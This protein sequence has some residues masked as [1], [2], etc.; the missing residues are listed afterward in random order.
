MIGVDDGA[1]DR[2][3][4]KRDVGEH[5]IDLPRPVAQQEAEAQHQRPDNKGHVAYKTEPAIIHQCLEPDIVGVFT[6]H[7]AELQRA[8]AQ[9]MLQRHEKADGVALEAAVPG[10]VIGLHKFGTVGEQ[11]GDL[12]E[13][14]GYDDRADQ[15]HRANQRHHQD[16]QPE[17]PG[18]FLDQH[19]HDQQNHGDGNETP[20]STGEREEH[21]Q[22]ENHQ[23]G[24][25]QRRSFQRSVQQS[26]HQIESR[27][28]QIGA[29][30]VGI[31]ESAHGA[32]IAG[33]KLSA[34][35]GAEIAQDAQK[36]RDDGCGQIGAKNQDQTP[37][38][39]LDDGGEKH[40]GESQEQ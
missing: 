31:L 32:A 10:A 11:I 21:A 30:H 29:E 36:R 1:D 35:Y 7:Q 5:Q 12:V 16:L 28:H 40:R 19:G 24:H 33:E 8:D 18:A 27:Q 9:R 37:L 15:Q 6:P 13:L 25:P 34:R 3:S 4:D 23:S 17:R 38:V 39:R 14:Q 22:H 26:V 2:V 20:G